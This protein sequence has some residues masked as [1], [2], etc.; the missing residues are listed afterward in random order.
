[1]TNKE[2]SMIHIQNHALYI[3]EKS[4]KPVH[5]IKPAS[6]EELAFMMILQSGSEGITGLDI[7]RDCHVISGRNFPSLLKRKAGVN[8]RWVWEEDST[9]NE[10][11]KRHWLINRDDAKKVLAVINCKRHSRGA[12]PLP[13]AIELPL[14]ALYPGAPVQAA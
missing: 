4:P 10:R 14:L 8:F 9:Q 13:T 2:K 7:Q 1:M 5:H 6:K 3:K 12:A 11:Y